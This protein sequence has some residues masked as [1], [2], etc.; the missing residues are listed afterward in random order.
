M[1]TDLQMRPP[2]VIQVG[3][4]SMTSVLTQ[5]RDTEGRSEVG[6]G[7]GHGKVETGCSHLPWDSQGQQKPEEATEDSAS[8]LWREPG[9]A[10][11]LISYSGLQKYGRE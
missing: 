4:N 5:R 8:G 3:L 10:N 11:N 7:G 6:L 1:V 9:L 2:S